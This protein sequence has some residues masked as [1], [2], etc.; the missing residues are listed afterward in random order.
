MTGNRDPE[1]ATSP[2]TS[3][4]TSTSTATADLA[5][6]VP[7]YCQWESPELVA[8]F[9]DGSL[10]AADDPRWAASGARTPREY[11]FWSFRACGM[12]CLKMLLAARGQ[13]VPP[14]MRL[15]ERGLACGAYVVDGD[16]VHGMIYRTFAGWVSRE[17]GITTEVMPELP[18]SVLARE[19]AAGAVVIASVHPW[20][21]WPERTPPAG[22]G[23]LVLVTRASD[24]MLMLNN[25]SGL[26][27]ES[28]HGA[29]I[30][31]ADFARFFAQR[32]ILVRA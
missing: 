28:Q 4:S 17:Y 25:P 27:G 32:G 16:A 21:R 14:T 23:H 5:A 9:L 1:L 7:Y 29:R 13:P 10:A 26:P 30:R 15:I 6:D 24:G 18:V 8:G 2:S 3:P 31:V 12:A 22:G 11:A 19:A 20:I